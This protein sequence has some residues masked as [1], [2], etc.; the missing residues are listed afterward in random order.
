MYIPSSFAEADEAK[1]FAL[2]RDNPFATVVSP[3]QGEPLIAHL[4]LLLDADRRMLCGHFAAANPQSCVEGAVIA[5]FHGPHAYVSPSWYVNPGVPTWNYAVVHVRGQLR[6]VVDASAKLAQ[7]RELVA[8]F[9]PDSSWTLDQALHLERMLEHIVTF[10]I[11]IEAIEGKFKMSQN[12]PADRTGV[13]EALAASPYPE[14]RRT[15]AF[16][17]EQS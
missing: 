14:D 13:I 9:E 1:L 7:M 11:A 10:E 5:V 16:M 6:H 8:A 17:L 15:A 4:P 2:M 12:R 3:G